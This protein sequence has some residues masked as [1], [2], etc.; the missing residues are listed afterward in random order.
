MKTTNKNHINPT[1]KLALAIARVLGAALKTIQMRT[2]EMFTASRKDGSLPFATWGR[3][4]TL[5]GLI[6][7]L[8][9]TTASAV[10]L[11]FERKTANAGVDIA[12][13]LS[14]EIV[15]AGGSALFLFMNSGSVVADAVIGQIYIED[16]NSTLSG[17]SFN[18]TETTT[19]VAFGSGATTPPG[20]PGVG[21]FTVDFS[22]G[23]DSPAPHNGVDIG[24]MGAFDGALSPSFADVEA[25][26]ISGDLR[27]ALHVI[28]IGTEDKSDSFLSLPSV[29]E[30]STSMLGLIGVMM[31]LR[32]RVR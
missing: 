8:A 11:S 18:T 7:I 4:S 22:Q 32:R 30:P 6:G 20:P 16:G 28:S 19:G 23:A 29:P 10:T 3:R 24:E 5:V 9:I 21:A 13:Q 1:A 15:D 14:V 17:F 26:L 25:A 12:D 27:I 31:I 2:N